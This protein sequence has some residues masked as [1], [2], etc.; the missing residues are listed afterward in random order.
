MYKIGWFSTG[1]GKGSQELL[2]AAHDAIENGDLKARIAFV[3]LS[4]EPG[5]APQTDKFIQQVRSY[6]IPLVYLSYQ[7]YKARYVT[8]GEENDDSLPQWRREYD[9]RVMELLKDYQTDICVLAGY[10]LIVGA[11]VCTAYRMI[12]LHPAAPGGPT[13]TWREVIWR[14]ID[15]GAS[16]T[17]VMMHLVTPQLDKGPVVTYTTFE[18]SGE[19]FDCL[20]EQIKGKTIARLKAAEGEE[21]ALFKL[22]RQH[23]M[24]RELP[25]VIA[26]LKAFSQGKVKVVDG[27][28]QD[29]RGNPVNGYD[30][31]SEIEE[32]LKS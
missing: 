24:A 16:E 7:K 9:L 19:P 4:R 30:L 23:G 8:I 27:R 1:R 32:R 17:G 15:T 2:R 25:L 31:T 26:T 13:G 14:L 22:I 28:V 6:N 11:E 12:N 21:N 3:F 5:E 20:W 18:I 29:G 10:M